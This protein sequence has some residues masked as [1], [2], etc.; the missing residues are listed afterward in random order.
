M[1]RLFFDICKNKVH[2]LRL[3]EKKTVEFDTIIAAY[4]QKRPPDYEYE[5]ERVESL[6]IADD[7]EKLAAIGFLFLEHCI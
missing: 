3:H 1:V 6:T 7:V 5:G 2:F 4:L